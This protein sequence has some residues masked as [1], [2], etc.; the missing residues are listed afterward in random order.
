MSQTRMRPYTAAKFKSVPLWK[1]K[2][3]DEECRSIFLGIGNQTVGPRRAV[4][5][6]TARLQQVRHQARDVV[7]IFH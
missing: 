3:E 7:L 1:H 2:V 5:S 4:Y 6:E